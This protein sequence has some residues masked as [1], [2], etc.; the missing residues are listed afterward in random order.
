MARDNEK[1]VPFLSI[2]KRCT[3]ELMLKPEMVHANAAVVSNINDLG[4]RPLCWG[5]R[6][7]GNSVFVVVLNM[8]VGYF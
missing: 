1:K 5:I 8:I 7:I 2:G 4:F 3:L 6:E